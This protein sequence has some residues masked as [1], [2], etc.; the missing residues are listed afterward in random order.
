M[1]SVH[2]GYRSRGRKEEWVDIFIQE[3]LR[4]QMRTMASRYSRLRAAAI[5]YLESKGREN[6]G[7]YLIRLEREV[8]RQR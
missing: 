1:S 3:N 2:A 5:D 6:E 7:G 8:G 4:D